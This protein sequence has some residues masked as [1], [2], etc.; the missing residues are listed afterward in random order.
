MISA[1]AGHSTLE[2][3]LSGPELE[4]SAAKE[5]VLVKWRVAQE[6]LRCLGR[7]WE[8]ACR[9]LDA[10]RGLPPGGKHCR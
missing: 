9:Q 8:V 4:A 7:E 2:G 5:W 3:P 6:Q 10:A 1:L